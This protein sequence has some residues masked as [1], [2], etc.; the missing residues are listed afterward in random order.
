MQCTGGGVAANH[1]SKFDVVEHE[2]SWVA[3]TSDWPIEEGLARCRLKR[4]KIETGRQV[5]SAFATSPALLHDGVKPSMSEPLAASSTNEGLALP[6]R[7]G[8]VSDRAG[9]SSCTRC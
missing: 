3:S 4:F 7:A 6:G 1:R 2:R 8:S 9:S 5:L